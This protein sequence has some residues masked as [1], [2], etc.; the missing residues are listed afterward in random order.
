MS[1]RPQTERLH[2]LP[3]GAA[4]LGQLVIDPRRSGG[5]DSPR[6]QAVA[7]QPTQR[8]R[9]HPLRNTA[10]HALDLIKMLRAIAEQDDDEHGP[11]VALRAP[12]WS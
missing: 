9:E 2:G 8:E 4:E 12:E 6:H 3:Q 1:A 5:E 11:L 10:D 7:L